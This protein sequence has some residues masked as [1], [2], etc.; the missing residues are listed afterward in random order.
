M[1]L[2]FKISKWGFIVL[3]ITFWLL[4]FSLPYLLRTY[5]EKNASAN[6]GEGPGLNFYILKCLFW[7]AFFYINAYLLFP[8]FIYKRDYGKYGFSLLLLMGANL[9]IEL[10]YFS[11]TDSL[12]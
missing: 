4:L 10:S 7:T 6:K 11:L 9:I 1:K 2:P 3:H 5:S 8:R 12:S